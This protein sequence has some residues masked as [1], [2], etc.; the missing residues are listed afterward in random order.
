MDGDFRGSIV[1]GVVGDVRELT[2]EAV[3]EP[4]FYGSLEQRPHTASRVSLIVR[5]PA[6]AVIAP[7][8]RRIIRAL[9]PTVAI[10][11]RTVRTAYDRTTAGRRFGVLLLGVFGGSAL[12]VALLGLYGLL[13]FVV[14]QRLKEM[15]IRMALGAT[16]LS[17]TRLVVGRGVLLAAVGGLLGITFSAGLAGYVKSF[18]FEVSALDPAAL[19]LVTAVAILAAT[20]ASYLPARRAAR[21]DP[22]ATLRSY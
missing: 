14:A 12:L 15:G 20:L 16:A 11:S 1:V 21:V 17:V 3:P 22:A 8:V 7:S 2:T 6:P 13:A 10:E 9:D 19:T 5:G 4:L 18:L